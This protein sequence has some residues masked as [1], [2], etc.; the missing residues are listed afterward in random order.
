MK[1]SLIRQN[2][3]TFNNGLVI[4]VKFIILRESS[5]DKKRSIDSNFRSA[6][7]H[8]SISKG[9]GLVLYWINIT[10]V[11]FYFTVE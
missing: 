9:S 5:T 8:Y 2:L 10:K 4:G 7:E 11:P 1:F 3:E 6:E